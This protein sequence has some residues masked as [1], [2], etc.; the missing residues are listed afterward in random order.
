MVLLCDAVSTTFVVCVVI[1]VRSCLVFLSNGGRAV[2]TLG[3][4]TTLCCAVEQSCDALFFAYAVKITMLV[5]CT[6]LLLSTVLLNQ[7]GA[8]TSSGLCVL[9]K[10]AGRTCLT[11]IGMVHA[12]HVLSV[13]VELCMD[14]SN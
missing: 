9:V 11:L 10:P 4:V 2:V 5:W 13:G 6:S 3:I 1:V 7:Y 8:P 14:V 12:W